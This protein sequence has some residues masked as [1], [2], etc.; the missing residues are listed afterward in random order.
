DDWR[1]MLEKI[2]EKLGTPQSHK[3]VRWHV[4]KGTRTRGLSGT[5]VELSYEATYEKYPAQVSM[6]VHKPIG[7]K[8]FKIVRMDID[9]RGLLLE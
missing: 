3:L 4:F 7:G 8:D 6:V 1:A 9:S 5:V 2:G